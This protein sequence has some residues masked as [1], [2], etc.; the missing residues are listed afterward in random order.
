MDQVPK[1]IQED[2]WPAL[3]LGCTYCVRCAKGRFGDASGIPSWRAG[4]EQALQDE[5]NNPYRDPK[6]PPITKTKM[7]NKFGR[8]AFEVYTWA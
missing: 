7:V 1:P 2:Q 4:V 8:Q 3:T 6:L 5:A